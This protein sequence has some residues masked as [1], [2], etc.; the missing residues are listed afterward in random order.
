MRG[1]WLPN[2]RISRAKPDSR[3][4]GALYVKDVHGEYY[5]KIN[6]DG[7]TRWSLDLTGDMRAVMREFA[8]RGVEYLYEVG[9]Q[10]GICCFCGRELS[11]PES[12]EC[13]YGPVCA[14]KYG[15]PHS[16]RHGF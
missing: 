8:M 16:N 14:R 7:S 1:V 4:P 9:K 2:V 12:V 5:G 6:P 13:G 11:D 15:L 10:T 3:N